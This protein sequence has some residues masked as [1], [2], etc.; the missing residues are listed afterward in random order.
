MKIDTSFLKNDC[1][2]IWCRTKKEAEILYENVIAFDTSIRPQLKPK[3]EM[4]SREKDEEGMG[5]RFSHTRDGLMVGYSNMWYYRKHGYT[6]LELDS[7]V[8]NMDFGQI[9][10]GYSNL[11]A[12]VAAL[13]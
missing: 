1:T 13:F 12:A 7:L 9:E 10:S 3:I 11:D 2:V 5:F 4:F 6:V 8:I